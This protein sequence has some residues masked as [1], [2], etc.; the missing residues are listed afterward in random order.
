VKRCSPV[1][2]GLVLLALAAPAEATF[3]GS[4]GKIA[5]VK[6]SS[7]DPS[8]AEVHTM[9]PDG[10]GDQNLGAGTAP[11]WSPD[12][13]KI[14]FADGGGL[15]V[16]NAD[17]SL[18]HQLT[19]A[20]ATGRVVGASSYSGHQSH[21]A[22][23]PDG[24]KIAFAREHCDTDPQLFCTSI[25]ETIKADGSGETTILQSHN[26]NPLDPTWSRDGG[27]IA[28]SGTVYANNFCCADIYAINPDGTGQT[29]LTNTPDLDDAS[30]DWSPDGF[31]LLA[32]N[33]NGLYTMNRDGSGVAAVGPGGSGA[34]AW[35]PDRQKVVFVGGGGV[36]T[37]GDVCVMNS[38]GTHVS[39]LTGGAGPNWQPIPYTGYARPRGATPFL[40]YLV[41]AYKPCAAPNRS[42]GTPLSFPSCSPPQP[43]SDYITVG[44]S[45]ANGQPNKSRGRVQFDALIDDPATPADE[46]NL[47]INVS[48]T[49]VRNKSDLSDYTGQLQ[50]TAVWRITDRYNGPGSDEPGTVVDIPVPYNL[51]CGATADTTVGSTCAMTSTADAIVPG[52]FQGHHRSIG[53]IGQITVYD[54]GADGTISSAD[55]TVFM[56]EGI[57]IP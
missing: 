54:G 44:T 33:D 6:P 30:V 42:H 16:M 8:V 14:A 36:A 3:P 24:T 19:G 46:G 48:I 35:S 13:T 25:L 49:D 4:N 20:N 29:Q 52:F 41:P 37:A 11:S 39:C 53:Q 56:V 31:K 26:P 9:N 43:T 50:E 38:D 21:P 15:W 1:I 32:G 12:G 28:F 23:S 7:G 22:W 18:R 45:D 27:R 40:T 10:S 34:G 51:P 2:L 57:F 47:L 5:Y 55:N 17:G